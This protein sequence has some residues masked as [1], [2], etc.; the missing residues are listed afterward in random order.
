MQTTDIDDLI[1]R[2]L[3]NDITPEEWQELRGWIDQ[4]EGNRATMR[5]MEEIW[6]STVTPKELSRFDKDK[7]FERFLQRTRS[8]SKNRQPRRLWWARWAVG[9]AAVVAVVMVGFLSYQGGRHGLQSRMTQVVVVAPMG[10]RTQTTLPDGT[11]VWLNAGS[12]IV[13]PQSF[14]INSREVEIEGEG[15]FTVAHD[16]EK[17][18]VLS[19]RSGRVKVLGTKFNLRDYADDSCLTVSLDEGSVLFSDAA[20]PGHFWTMKPGQRITLNKST[21]K[22]QLRSDQPSER[23]WTSGHFV[24]GGESLAEIALR[25]QRQYNVKIE[26]ANASL[27]RLH[28][29][30]EFGGLD[31]SINDVLQALAATNKVR[32][33]WEGNKIVLF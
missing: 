33:K 8:E 24:L 23:A 10:S 31:T 12:R 7:A 1:I 14:G 25:L 15:Y 18:F 22:I 32:Y 21:G 5:H 26:F 19:S 28:F 20:R 4:N 2:Y 17:P 9:V 11:R 3:S 29:Q 13:Y 30:G 6:F 16:A 27:R